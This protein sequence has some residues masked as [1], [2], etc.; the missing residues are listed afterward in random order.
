MEILINFPKTNGFLLYNSLY[1]IYSINVGVYLLLYYLLCLMLFATYSIYDFKHFLMK[2]IKIDLSAYF[3]INTFSNI[4]PAPDT[5]ARIHQ[6]LSHLLH[7][8]TFQLIVLATAKKPSPNTIKYLR[9]RLRRYIPKLF[10]V[11]SLLCFHFRALH[12]HPH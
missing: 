8:L 2:T 12:H 5:S 11:T 7:I 10:L 1:L 9:Q 3:Y 4:H 6:N